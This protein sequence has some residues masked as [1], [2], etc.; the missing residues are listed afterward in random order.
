MWELGRAK[1]FDVAAGSTQDTP[2]QCT[3]PPAM[4]RTLILLRTSQNILL[5]DPIPTCIEVLLA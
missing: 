4:G 3:L 1:S 2:S 5:P